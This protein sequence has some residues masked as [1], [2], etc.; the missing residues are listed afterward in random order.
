V[1]DTIKVAVVRTDRRRGAVAEALALIAADLRRQVQAD[2]DP[3]IIPNLD[4]PS[5]AWACTH[6]DTLSATADAVLGAGASS[7]IIAGAIG[8]PRRRARG[9]DAFQGLGYRSELWGRP[10]SFR[11]I[12][13]STESWKAIRGLGPHGEPLAVRVP[14]FVAA[15]RCRISLG[16]ARTHEVFRV[17]L[18]LAN[19]R[20]I[21]LGEDRHLLGRSSGSLG[22]LVPGLA[23]AA[24]LVESWRG[25]L[26]RAWWAIRS[27]SGGMRVTG[28][29]A[30]LLDAAARATHQLVAIAASL[31]PEVS[32]ID[33][34]VGMQGEGPRHGSRVRLG[35]VIA[36]TD[37]IAVDAVAAALM[38]FEPMEIAYL[39]H[40]QAMGL[41]TAELSAIT[42][43][44]DPVAPLR[45]R[46]RRHA[47]DRLLRLVPGPLVRQGGTPQPHFGSVPSLASL[48]ESRARGDADGEYSAG[49]KGI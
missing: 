2:P 35:T 26:V 33:G 36:G 45:R 23:M 18:G 22:R 44:G 34:F 1:D 16:V 42:V 4:L 48:A 32:L 24:G 8:G 3:V 10:A 12:D 40:A 19:L 37:A 13:S 38:G 15:S 41:G 31:L 20:G 47:S 11:E 30:R 21:L 14:S 7:I 25:W 28:P 5:R 27:V 17:G 43:V 49:D 46:F 9:S 29:E 6:R 39:R